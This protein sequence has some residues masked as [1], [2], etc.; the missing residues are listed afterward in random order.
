M[1]KSNFWES[2]VP[3]ISRVYTSTIKRSFLKS[4]IVSKRQELSTSQQLDKAICTTFNKRF[5]NGRI[6]GYDKN[7]NYVS[8]SVSPYSEVFLDNIEDEMKELLS[9]LVHNGYLPISSCSSHEMDDKRYVTLCFTSEEKA[10][11][12]ITEIQ[13]I[14]NKLKRLTIKKKSAA[15]YLN[16]E[17][18][19]DKYGR[20]NDVTRK[21]Q[22]GSS[23]PDR[24]LNSMFLRNS[25]DWWTVELAIIDDILTE[26]IIKLGNRFIYKKF[27]IERDTKTL[28]DYIEFLGHSDLL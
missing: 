5:E 7:G 22:K 14:N 18:E 2:I 21:M 24:Y 19:T 6:H 28:N 23:C 15:E 3:A 16:M 1:N 9:T 17:I 8:H 10:N 4:F 11:S 13:E 26:N 20:I 12:F 25:D 27:F